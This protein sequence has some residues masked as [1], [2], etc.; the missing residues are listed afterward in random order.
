VFWQ[1]PPPRERNI[2]LPPPYQ[3]WLAPW[4]AIARHDL[5]D[6][7]AAAW[8]EGLT[9]TAEPATAETLADLDGGVSLHG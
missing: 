1:A 4:V 6:A 3:T 9:L 8:A 2:Y 5:G 7:A